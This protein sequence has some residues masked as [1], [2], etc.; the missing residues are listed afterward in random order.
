MSPVRRFRLRRSRKLEI[1]EAEI[2]LRLEQAVENI[3]QKL[4]NRHFMKESTAR[5][6]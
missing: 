1:E 5:T 3:R 6:T 4:A 2:R